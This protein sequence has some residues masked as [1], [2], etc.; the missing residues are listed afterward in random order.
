MASF[1]VV[2]VVLASAFL[3]FHGVIADEQRRKIIDFHSECLDVHGV[4]EE[5]FV[6]ALDGQIPDDD[7]FYEHL[8][9]AAKKAKI[10]TEDGTVNLDNFEEELKDVINA[11]NMPRIA[12]IMRKC[13]VQKS[14]IMDTIK[15][16][17][18]CFIKEEH[19]I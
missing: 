18:D 17:V 11:P 2:C 9:C 3:A 10:M 12:A 14:E 7:A 8:F 16:A 13:L 4:D 5:A 19:G 1:K 6:A 15:S